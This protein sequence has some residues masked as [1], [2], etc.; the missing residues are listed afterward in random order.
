MSAKRG[1]PPKSAEGTARAISI[2]LPPL[3]K[4]GLELLANDSNVSM[5]Q[6]V[7]FALWQVFPTHQLSS[8]KTVSEIL[9]EMPE[10]ASDRVR[11]MVVYGINPHLTDFEMRDMLVMLW[12]SFEMQIIQS[13]PGLLDGE[14]FRSKREF[15]LFE[16]YD[17]NW[18][19]LERLLKKKGNAFKSLRLKE[20]LAHELD[21]EGFAKAIKEKYQKKT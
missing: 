15:E 9:E 1:R 7:H 20:E 21:P 19:A 17:S 12:T 16:W 8:G 13:S 4:L 10:K 11:Q 5:A 14:N 2:R 6:A 18:D 3:T